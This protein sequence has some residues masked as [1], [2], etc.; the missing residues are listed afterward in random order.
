MCEHAGH[1]LYDFSVGKWLKDL[2][3]WPDRHSGGYH[4]HGSKCYSPRKV[5]CEYTCM[6]A[7]T[8][9]P[10]HPPARPPARPPTRAPHPHAAGEWAS[11][12]VVNA[13][14]CGDGCIYD[15]DIGLDVG[16]AWLALPEGCR[17]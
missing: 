17:L 5:E 16:C 10:A 4:C 3:F 15:A 1:C 2:S 14:S 8:H 11:T 7:P 6:P 13:K 12:P 9:L